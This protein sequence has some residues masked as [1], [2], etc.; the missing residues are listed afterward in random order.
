MAEKP[1]IKSLT[2]EQEARISEFVEK[3]SRRVE[4]PTNSEA[5]R[6]HVLL[7]YEIA[8]LPPP[9]IIVEVASPLAAQFAHWIAEVVDDP[10][11]IRALAEGCANPNTRE[12]TVKKCIQ[13]GCKPNLRVYHSFQSYGG[14][15]DYGWVSYYDYIHEV[16][17]VRY[18]ELEMRYLQSMYDAGVYDM[19]LYNDLAIYC[20]N[21][22]YIKRSD[23]VYPRMH[24]ADSPAIAWSDGVELYFWHGVEVPRKYIME[25]DSITREDIMG[26]TNA[27]RRRALYEILGAERWAELLGVECIDEDI[28]DQGRM[29]RLHRTHEPDPIAEEYLYFLECVC[30]STGRVYFLSV[31]PTLDPVNVWSA[32][33]WLFNEQ[34]I[35]YVRE[36]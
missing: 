17:G 3:W 9:K 27:E 26:E 8:K 32:K 7:M 30:P 5:A 13:L 6:E 10:V 22:L 2:P 16:L 1:K 11:Q 23:R 12:E 19:L 33:A 35:R 20:C 29:M 25:K 4:Q 31:P 34:A 21:P 14:C 24:S 18:G 15:G 36:T 28:D